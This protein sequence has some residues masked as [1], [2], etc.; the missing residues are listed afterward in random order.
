ME[1]LK[2][3][4]KLL[5][6]KISA[7]CNYADPKLVEQVYY[8]TLRVILDELRTNGKVW[9]PDWGKFRVTEYKRRKIGNVNTGESE[10]IPPTKVIKFDACTKL[11]YYVKNKV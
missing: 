9:M 1:E 11:K 8:A 4:K 7:K 10:W 6:D 5:M 3:S 2:L